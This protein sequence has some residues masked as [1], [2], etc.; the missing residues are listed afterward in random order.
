MSPASCTCKLMVTMQLP[1]RHM[2]AVRGEAKMDLFRMDLAA[3]RRSMNYLTVAH[4]MKASASTNASVCVN[5]APYA[6]PSRTISSHQKY[7]RAFRLASALASL[8]A[9]VGMEE[10]EARLATLHDQWSS[11]VP[12]TLI[13]MQLFRF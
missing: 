6:S 10:F 5:V 12:S 3:E 8:V 7:N 2:F 13:H 9:E 11:H 4:I 1:C